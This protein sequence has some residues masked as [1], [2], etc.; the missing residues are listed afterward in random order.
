MRKRDVPTL[1]FNGTL[2]YTWCPGRR[3]QHILLIIVG[4]DVVLGDREICD[5][6]GNVILREEILNSLLRW[7][8]GQHRYVGKPGSRRTASI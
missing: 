5:E 1:E 3:S 2:Q 4:C 7:S 8:R 6:M